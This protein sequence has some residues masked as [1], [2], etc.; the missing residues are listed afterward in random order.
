MRD[1]R[2][3]SEAKRGSELSDNRS[4]QSFGCCSSCRGLN[5]TRRLQSFPILEK[6][7]I[8]PEM[9]RR[10]RLKMEALLQTSIA[11]IR[12]GY[13]EALNIPG[14]RKF[15]S[16]TCFLHHRRRNFPP[17]P[18]LDPLQDFQAC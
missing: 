16:D 6:N 15:R 8:L 9:L 12:S 13:P 2:N 7:M 3:C 1:S 10:L 17:E 5:R 11:R 18:G 4:T 14:I